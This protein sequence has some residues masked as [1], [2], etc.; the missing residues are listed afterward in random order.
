MN[1]DSFM[2]LLN[3]YVVV[4][5]NLLF[6]PRNLGKIPNFDINRFRV[7]S[8]PPALASTL[9]ALDEC[10]CLV[11]DADVGDA[12]LQNAEILRAN[13]YLWRLL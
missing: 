11:L 7:E 13:P 8:L 3:S 1:F 5:D 12:Q 10:I 6:S 9:Q 2:M 4:L